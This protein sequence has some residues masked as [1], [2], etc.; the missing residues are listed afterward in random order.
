MTHFSLCFADRDSIFTDGKVI[1][2]FLLD[3]A[4]FIKV[5]ECLNVFPITVEVVRHGIMCGIQKKLFYM[6]IR[7]K[8]FYLE[9]GMDKSVGI[10]H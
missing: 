7:Q 8:I 6:E 5:N 1:L 3:A 9:K 2:V 4:F 10:V